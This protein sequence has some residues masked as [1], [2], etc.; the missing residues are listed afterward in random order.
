[1]RRLMILWTLLASVLIGTGVVLIVTD[2]S[3]SEEGPPPPG[4]KKGAPRIRVVPE[5]GAHLTAAGGKV[6]G[7]PFTIYHAVSATEIDLEIRLLAGR[8]RD[9]VE[10][11][12]QRLARMHDLLV[13]IFPGLEAC[14]DLKTKGPLHLLTRYVTPAELRAAGVSESLEDK[15]APVWAKLPVTLTPTIFRKN[16]MTN[17]LNPVICAYS[18][19]AEPLV[20][21]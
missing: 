9:L 17:T 5:V 1:M 2:K 13:G 11:Q 6:A 21:L 8:R 15:A 4:P 14:L 18:A 3:G 19:A 12:T 20:F 7:P 10:A 16:I